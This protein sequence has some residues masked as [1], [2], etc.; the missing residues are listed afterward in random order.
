MIFFQGSAIIDKGIT[1]K[2]LRLAR[3]DTIIGSIC[4]VFIAVCCILIGAALF[5]HTQILDEDN[6]STIILA[7]NDLFG[8]WAGTLFGFGLFNAGFL[9]AITISLSSSWTVAEAFNWKHSLNEKIT[10]APKFYAVYIGSLIVA[11]LLILIPNLPLNFIAVLTQAIGGM[12]MVPVL[13]FI[14]ILTN[15]KKYMGKYKNSL[16]ANIWGWFVVGVLTS[17][18][19]LLFWQTFMM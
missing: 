11:A 12:L 1:A 7:L 4:Q 17:L 9:A 5:G 18:I 3:I 6:P 10:T 15:N 16:F 14:M 8:P 2:E 13:I 19:V